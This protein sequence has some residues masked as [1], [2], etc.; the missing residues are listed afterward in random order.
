MSG[1][2]QGPVQIHGT[3]AWGGIIVPVPVSKTTVHNNSAT[4]SAA[5][6]VLK[7]SADFPFIVKYRCQFVAALEDVALLCTVVLDTGTG[8][9][10]LPQAPL[11]IQWRYL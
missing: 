9:I 8:T 7:K 6:D 11:Q 4:S 5:T 2:L 3:G 10:I 1:R